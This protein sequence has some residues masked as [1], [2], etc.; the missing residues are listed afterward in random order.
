MNILD[1]H[2]H[3]LKEN[4]SQYIYS[5]MPSAFSPREGGY[6]SVGIHPWN[7]NSTTE[8]EYECLKKIASHPQVIA[9]GEAG[10]DKMIPIDLSIQKEIF[11]WQIELSETL[12]KPLIIHSVRTSNE[13]IQLKKEFCPKSPWIIHG[14]R[15]KKELAD[16]LTA[17]NI[18]LSFGEKYQESAIK[19]IPL[20]RLLLE[21]DESEKEILLIYKSVA[22]IHS[23]TT[24][25]LVTQVQQNIS[26]LFFNR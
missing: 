15:G 23:L 20:N 22:Q 9:I 8:S 10:L 14:F 24:E 7:I 16:Q 6:Y 13:I 25:Q 4:V 1:I 11:R 21:T 3:H 17:Q 18:Y 5:C 2:T 12:S 19:S 26:R